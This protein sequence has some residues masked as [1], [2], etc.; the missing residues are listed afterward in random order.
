MID[1]R[2][3]MLDRPLWDPDLGCY[4]TI[5]VT[6]CDSAIWLAVFLVVRGYV[7]RLSLFRGGKSVEGIDADDI[8]SDVMAEVWA[9]WGREKVTVAQLCGRAARRVI[10]LHRKAERHRKDHDVLAYFQRVG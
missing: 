3:G 5:D 8:A 1:S 2:P 6:A 4:V 10:D 9:R 7:A